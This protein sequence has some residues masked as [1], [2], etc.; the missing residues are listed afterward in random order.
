MSDDQ[1]VTI[2]CPSYGH[3]R[4]SGDALGSFVSQSHHNLE[5]LVINDKSPDDSRRIIKEN[6]D[7]RIRLIENGYNMGT[8]NSINKA[9]RE[10]RGSVICIC[11]SD[12]IMRPD[13]VSHVV[14]EFR[15]D[16]SIGAVYPRLEYIDE[17]N[18]NT[19]FAEYGTSERYSLLWEMFFEGNNSLHAPGS[20]FLK[21]TLGTVGF[22]NPG[23]I[24]TQDYDYN[25]RTLLKHN[26][27][28]IPDYTIRYR[29]MSNHTNLSGGAS[30]VSRAYGNEYGTVLDN[31]LSIDS[32]ELFEGVFQK[33][34]LVF[35][36]LKT[37]EIPFCVAMS[38]IRSS[39]SGLVIWG[40]MK[41]KQIISESG[42]WDYLHDIYGF[43]YKDFIALY[44]E[45]YPRGNDTTFMKSLL[46]KNIERLRR[47]IISIK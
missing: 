37:R 43:S 41:I 12:D 18:N 15:K 47:I 19:G 7:R 13:H 35:R 3:E 16:T 33:E 34:D 25:V 42:N 6:K 26:V 38:A 30:W 8:S 32:V 28:I 29:R 27:A 1:L 4:F 22:F 11:S 5:I 14:E 44:I 39:N 45:K 2:I 21:E 46:K 40:F 20:A 24:Q 36:P 31:Y 10:A 17:R 9:V 23:L